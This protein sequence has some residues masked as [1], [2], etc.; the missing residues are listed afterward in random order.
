MATSP[1]AASRL[2]A[3]NITH[4]GYDAMQK[5]FEAWIEARPNSA[6]ASDALVGALNFSKNPDRVLGEAQRIY[7]EAIANGEDAGGGGGLTA[8]DVESIVEA[9][10]A[11]ERGTVQRKTGT[12]AP[13]GHE[14]AT[15]GLATPFRVLRVT[16]DYPAR[17]RLYVSTAQRD[18][19]VDRALDADPTGN[20]G[21]LLEVVTTTSML[22]VDVTPAAECYVDNGSAN[23]PITVE[24][25]D[26]VNRAVT[27]TIS[28]MK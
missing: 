20:H 9:K 6:V 19:D 4:V 12:L 27:A 26:T 1:I 15:L 10:T 22:S 16:T 24:N 8:Q 17:V 21:Q 18:A 5:R 14:F 7:D 13:K 23:V 2:V 3:R 25:L 11:I 28:Y